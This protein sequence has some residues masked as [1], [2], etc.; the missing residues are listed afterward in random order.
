MRN[1][2]LKAKSLALAGVASLMLVGGG[3]AVSTTSAEAGASTGT[4]RYYNP[5]RGYGYR[6]GYYGGYRPYYGYRRGYNRGAAVAAGVATGLALGAIAASRPAYPAYGYPAYAGD[7]YWVTRER[8]N[9][10]GEIVVRR[11]QVCD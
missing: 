7:C 11:V 4:W 3:L 6:G 5:Y 9:R 2:I 10:W 8:V 1:L